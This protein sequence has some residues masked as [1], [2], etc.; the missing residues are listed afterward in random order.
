MIL[1]TGASGQVGTYLLKACKEK[2]IEARTWIHSRKSEEAA[3][4][5]R[6]ERSICRRHELGRCRGRGYAGG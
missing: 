2:G 4:R 5:S 1:L 6:G 3:L